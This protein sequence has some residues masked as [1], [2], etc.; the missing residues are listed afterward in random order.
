MDTL[1]LILV[2]DK[3]IINSLYLFRNSIFWISVILK[4]SDYYFNVKIQNSEY[5]KKLNIK[6]LNI[7][8]IYQINEKSEK[9]Y[10]KKFKTKNI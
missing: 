6:N 4:N 3:Y 10:S 2:F 1:K 8:Q 9:A 5:F 7:F